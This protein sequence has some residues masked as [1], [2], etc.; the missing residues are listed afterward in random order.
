MPMFMIFPGHRRPRENDRPSAES[1]SPESA[2]NGHDVPSARQAP[3]GADALKSADP[4]RSLLRRPRRYR[5]DGV[6]GLRWLG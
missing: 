1:G 3:G 5:S 4:P 2:S 6:L